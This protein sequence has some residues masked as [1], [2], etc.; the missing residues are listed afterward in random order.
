[1]TLKYHGL[2]LRGPDS[3]ELRFGIA[4][5]IGIC[6]S[7]RWIGNQTISVMLKKTLTRFHNQA[8]LQCAAKCKETVHKLDK[9]VRTLGRSMDIFE[10]KEEFAFDGA[11]MEKVGKLL[12]ATNDIPYHLDSLL[13]YLR[14][15]ADCVAFAIPFFFRTNTTIANRSFR[16]HRSWFLEKRPDFDS[17]YSAV[18]REKTN[19]F[20][21]L[22]GKAPKGVRDLQ[23]HQFATYQLGCVKLPKG[24]WTI[25]VQ[26]VTAKGISDPNL[27]FTLA[28]IIAD[29]FSYLDATYA[30]FAER[31]AHECPDLMIRS[32]EEESVFMGYSGYIDLRKQYR[33]YP[34]IDASI[35]AEQLTPADDL[36]PPLT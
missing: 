21:K 12:Q 20:D 8:Y 27:T 35:D 30:L 9:A 2:N 18:L 31:L 19:W 23:F 3:G 16:D 13:A 10:R 17:A 25:S 32:L 6:Q 11:P 34:L 22:A 14:I 7:L 5:L 29:F 33:L 36:Q 1:M 28:G 4:Q 26:Q 24:E 15:L